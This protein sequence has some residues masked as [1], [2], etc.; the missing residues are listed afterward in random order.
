MPGADVTFLDTLHDGAASPTT[1]STTEHLR[2]AAR[3]HD[4][5]APPTTETTRFRQP[6][7]ETTT[8]TGWSSETTLG[9]ESKMRRHI[10]THVRVGKQLTKDNKLV[11]NT[12][13]VKT[14]TTDEETRDE[15]EEIE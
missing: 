2:P 14:I 4:G 3:D 8:E 1:E 13:T 9:G 15:M 12:R 10:K 11:T 6:W 5:A 7:N